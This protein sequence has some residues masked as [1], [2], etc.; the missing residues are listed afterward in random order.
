MDFLQLEAFIN[1]AKFK[2]FHKAAE[3]LHITQPAIS[4][5]IKKLEAE[6]GV[7]LFERDGNKIELTPYGEILAPYAWNMLNVSREAHD[8]INTFK[9][10]DHYRLE[11]GTTS[12]LG[13]YL[14]P[15]LLDAFKRKHPSVEIF[16][17][18]DI[19][20]NILVRLNQDIIHIGLISEP[21][22]DA[23]LIK[24][25]LMEDI[26]ELVCSPTHPL[27][28]QSKTK[29]VLSLHEINKYTIINFNKETNFYKPIFEIFS[30]YNITP[31]QNISVDNIEAMKRMAANMIGVAFLPKMAIQNEINEGQLVSIPFYHQERLKR[32]TFIVYRKKKYINPAVFQFVA[33]VQTVLKENMI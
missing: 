24:I 27:Y 19:S 26:I 2:N 14:L 28:K 5:R 7:D 29:Q 3:Q 25:P 11:I 15:I 20:D 23:N 33:T 4:S 6:L 22:T 32:G 10:K 31:K 1:I 8:A 18:T 16:I 9:E 30:M 13:T 21:T 12:R 17:E